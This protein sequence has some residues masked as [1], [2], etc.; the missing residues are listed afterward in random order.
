M[1]KLQ[2]TELEREDEAAWDTYVY[3]SATST[4]YH[5][6]RSVL[7]EAAKRITK[8]QGADYLELLY[9]HSQEHKPGLATNNH[10]VTSILKLNPDPE[11]VGKKC[12]SKVR[13]A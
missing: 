11:I 2:I 5:Q 10:Y 1:P 12:N 9:L 3:S 13:N 8:A 4:F 6:Q 7:V